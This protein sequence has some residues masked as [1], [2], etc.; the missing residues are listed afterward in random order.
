MSHSCQGDTDFRVVVLAASHLSINNDGQVLA[1]WLPP[2]QQMKIDSQMSSHLALT[3]QSKLNQ[4]SIDDL[5]ATSVARLG[6]ISP[7]W[8][9]FK[10]I[11]ATF[12]SFIYYL[13]KLLTYLGKYFMLLCIFTFYKLPNIEY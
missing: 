10:S 13:E 2:S 11:W 6:E 1:G 9:N 4:I 3:N 12:K 7:L 8:Q 5:S